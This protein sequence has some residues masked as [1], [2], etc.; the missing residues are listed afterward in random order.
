MKIQPTLTINVDDAVFQVDKMSPGVQSMIAYFDDW[1]QKEANTTS[2]LLMI[3]AA[4]KDIQ[5]SLL[6]TIQQER[7]EALKKAEALG[8]I[9]PSTETSDDTTEE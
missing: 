4:L 2:E 6:E 3:R 7:A 1:R 9:P 8:I 5:A